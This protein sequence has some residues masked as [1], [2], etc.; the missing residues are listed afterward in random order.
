DPLVG[1]VGRLAGALIHRLRPPGVEP[2]V[3]AAWRH[4]LRFFD[5]FY[6]DLHHFASNLAAATDAG[7]IKAACGGIRRAIEGDD[8]P[9]IA[10]SHDGARM[11]PARGLSI[12]FPP[13]RDPSGFYRDLYFAHR[14][15]WAEFLDAYLGNGRK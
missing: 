7:E 15:R 4:T 12:Y 14:A 2:A 5:N 3:Y 9:I 13:F 10:A 1:G 6:V 11:A 8:S